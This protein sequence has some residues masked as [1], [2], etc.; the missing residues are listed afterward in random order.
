MSQQELSEIFFIGQLEP[1]GLLRHFLKHPPD[2]FDPFV[3]SDGKPGFFTDFDLLTTADAAIKRYISAVP[4]SAILRRLL[5]INTCF[6]GTTVSEYAPIPCDVS[7]H[8]LPL[9]M[10]EVWDRRS[11]LMIV[12]DIP[13]Q[14]PLISQSDNEHAAAFLEACVRTGYEIIEGQAL[15]YV[16]ISFSSEEEY[17]ERLS[18][19]RR[20]NIRRKLRVRDHLRIEVLVTGNIRFNDKAFLDELYGLYGEVYNQSEIHFDHLSL[21]FF[22]AVLQD[23]TLNGQL[24][25]YYH[26]GRLIGFNLCF[27]HANMLIDKYVGFRYPEARDQN[28]YFVSWME[29]LAFARKH[30]LSHYVAGWTDP[31]IKSYLG[32]QFT[33]TQHAIYVRNRLLRAMLHR[34]SKRFESDRNWF[35]TINHESATD[36]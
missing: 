27:V 19:S 15:A 14:S 1:I 31:E 4:G 3:S 9:K 18:S 36:S 7:P 33:F 20:K 6:F 10:L 30:G 17:L 22:A 34:F 2:H 24:F 13:A 23:P 32:A 8:V 5:R 21:D 12:K 29:N 35:D 26:E 11:I 25:L 16:P 28:L